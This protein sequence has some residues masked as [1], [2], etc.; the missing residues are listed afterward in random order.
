MPPK[1][2]LAFGVFNPLQAQGPWSSSQSGFLLYN[3]IFLAIARAVSYSSMARFFC[4][5]GWFI[6]ENEMH[7]LDP[8]LW[9]LKPHPLPDYLRKPAFFAIA[10]AVSYSS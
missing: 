9:R 3:P 6:I 7:F 2:F 10:R 4:S 8:G 5:A 1:K